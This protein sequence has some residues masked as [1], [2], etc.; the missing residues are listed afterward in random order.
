MNYFGSAAEMQVFVKLVSM[1]FLVGS[2]V[3]A[4]ACAM[5]RFSLG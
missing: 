1:K 2:V 4:A 5:H 3:T